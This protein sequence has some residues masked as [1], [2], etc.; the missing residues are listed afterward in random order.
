MDFMTGLLILTDWE[1]HS[2]DAILVILDCLIEMVYYKPVKS[3]IDT[4]SLAEIIINM[5]VRYHGF[6]K[7]IISD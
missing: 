7:S 1:K 6:L 3:I 4:A 5:I 2:Y